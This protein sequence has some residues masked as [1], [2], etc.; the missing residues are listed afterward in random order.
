M[1]WV[2]FAFGSNMSLKQMQER[3]PNS[4]KIDI[5]MLE[6]YRLIFPRHSTKR[7]CGVASIAPCEGE[8][9]WGIIYELDNE[10]LTKLDAAE[11]FN[12]L[13]A[14]EKNNYNR[15]SVQIKTQYP[16]SEK[17]DCLTY[18]AV[19]QQGDFFP[20]TQYIHTILEGAEENNLPETYVGRLRDILT[21]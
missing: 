17:I 2:Y 12:P 5:G 10:D 8:V 18:L 13:R 20:N 19:P 21:S 15:I 11:G 16:Q 9:I 14:P 4:K 6:N 1:A 7:N 3:C